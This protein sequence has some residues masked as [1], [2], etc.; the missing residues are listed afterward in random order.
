MEMFEKNLTW[1]I[2]DKPRDKRVVGYKWIY[3]VKCK[4]DGTLER[5]KARLTY[6][7]D[8]EETFTLVTNMNTIRNLQQF[9]VKNVFLHRDL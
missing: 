2:V 8:H 4:F 3:I 6:G 7:I 9:D 1:E 5:Y